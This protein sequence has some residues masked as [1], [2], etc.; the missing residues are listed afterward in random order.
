MK[1]WIYETTD[2]GIKNPDNK[3]KVKTALNIRME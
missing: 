3:I 2:N 1:P